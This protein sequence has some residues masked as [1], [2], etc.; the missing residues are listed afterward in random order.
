MKYWQNAGPLDRT[1]RLV[2]AVIAAV[3]ALQTHGAVAVVSWLVCI[4]GLVSGLSGLVLP[5]KLLGI[6]TLKKRR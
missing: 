2:A 4:I 3:V 5:Y 1:V 6:T